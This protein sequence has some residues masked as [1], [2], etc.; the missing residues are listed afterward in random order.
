MGH[1]V[2]E[3][4]GCPDTGDYRQIAQD[5]EPG[6]V[7]LRERADVPSSVDGYVRDSIDDLIL[8]ARYRWVAGGHPSTVALQVLKAYEALPPP[9]DVML[10]Q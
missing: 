7:V 1:W 3:F 4:S 5:D 8:V 10:S 6:E 9:P 2:Y